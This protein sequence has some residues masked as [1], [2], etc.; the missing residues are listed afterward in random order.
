MIHECNPVFK[1][2]KPK[3]EMIEYGIQVSSRGRYAIK[4][5]NLVLGV[6]SSKAE[7]ISTIDSLIG[8]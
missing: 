4:K 1:E 5:N 8:D 6:Y 7:A 3:E 2:M